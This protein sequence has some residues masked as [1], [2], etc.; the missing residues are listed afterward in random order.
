MLDFFNRPERLLFSWTIEETSDGG[1][2]GKR[3]SAIG[4]GFSPLFLF[5]G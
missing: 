5:R 4:R 2:V 3:T 1:H